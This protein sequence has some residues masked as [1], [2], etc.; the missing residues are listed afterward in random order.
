M[1]S[2]NSVTLIG[3]LAAKPELKILA[4]GQSVTSLRLATNENWVAK[5]GTKKNSVCWHQVVVWGKSAESCAKYLDKG[6]QVLVEGKIQNRSYVDK[7]GITRYVSEVVADRVQFLGG[8]PSEAQLE[9]GPETQAPEETV[10]SL[11]EIPF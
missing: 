3:N 10:D 7:E 11:D 4:S 1:S 5:D 6:R 9:N 8:K 2:L